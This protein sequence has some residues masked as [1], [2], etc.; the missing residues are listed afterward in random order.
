MT[1]Q[2]KWDDH[3]VGQ[4][5]PGDRPVLLLV[6]M[7]SAYLETDSPLYMASAN[8]ALL[9]SK[10]LL[11]AA[12]SAKIPVIYTT[13]RYLPDGSDG[14]HFFRKVPALSV[15]AGKNKFGFIP[16]IL[17]P[18]AIEP[19]FTKQYPSAFFNT[20]L[21]AHLRTLG[22]NTVLLAGYSTSG[23]VRA[24][25]LDALQHGFIPIVAADGCADRSRQI[26]DA[27]LYD[28]GKK[29]AEVQNVDDILLWLK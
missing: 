17:A 20:G 26:H 16:E 19:I 13:V 3:Y 7:V 10:R 24:S 8:A 12:R 22:V 9:A 28:I 5:Q 6:D 27:N 18:R 4:L 29:Y 14:G 15:W 2:L 11:E 23:C 21:N 25:A 1:D